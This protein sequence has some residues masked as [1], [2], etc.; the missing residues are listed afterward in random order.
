MSMREAPGRRGLTRD[1]PSS[2]RWMPWVFAG[3]TILG[4]IVWVLAGSWRD[5]ITITTVVTFALA[6][7]SHAWITRGAS[8]TA[9]YVVIAGGIGL[10]VEAIGTST[11]LP[12]GEYS[13]ADSLGPKVLGVPIVVPLAWTMMSYPVLLAAQR[14]ARGW[15]SVTVIGAWLLTSW[16]L[17]L[18]PQM[19]G[20]GH[21]TWADP[22][23]A[24]PGIP[25]IPITNYG[26]WLLT[27]LVIIGLLALLPRKQTDEGVP[28][29]MLGWVFA[30]NILANAVFFGQPWVAL[31]GGVAMA[32]VVVPWA[33]VRWQDRA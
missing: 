3:L 19:V 29:L 26:G 1:E 11:G 5:A 7:I 8:W 30:S 13:Y 10:A 18:D 17:F 15:I 32:V 21:W 12:F 16:D 20:E 27:S 14:L 6:S 33:R 2:L 28:T 25:G 9:M 22:T 24:L 31:W 23:P 4:Q